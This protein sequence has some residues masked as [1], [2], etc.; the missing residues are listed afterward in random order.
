MV[1]LSSM[2]VFFASA[3]FF[4]GLWEI[5]KRHIKPHRF[6]AFHYSSMEEEQKSFKISS[7]HISSI[8]KDKDTGDNT[9]L[10]YMFYSLVGGGC[11]YFLLSG[12]IG[13]PVGIVV[14]F[15][16]PKIMSERKKKMQIH[17]VSMQ[18]EKAAE[19]MAVVLKSGGG[20]PDALSKA[21]SEAA[22]PLRIEI[23]RALSEIQLG[24]SESD[25]FQRLSMR[26]GVPEVDMLGVASVLKKE[27]MAVN[28]ANVLRQ[29]QANIRSKQA[30]QEEISALTAE[31]RM[32]VWIVSSVPFMTLGAMQ[33]FAPDFIRPLFNT[34][35]GSISLFVA[36]ALIAIGVIWSLKIAD[37]SASILEKGGS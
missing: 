21:G 34:A 5:T 10:G 16:I 9:L 29:I 3:L 20:I 32:A 28:M 7:S 19:S 25:A 14:G 4:I 1:L 8:M 23:D 13:I 30:F 31:N 18:V 24:V 27:G 6:K 33:I 2:L 15:I 35:I 12:W 11:G 26:I 36:I 37:S 22:N 17:V